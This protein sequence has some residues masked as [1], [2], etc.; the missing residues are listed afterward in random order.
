MAQETGKYLETLQ[1]YYEEEIE[2]EAYFD[3]IAERLTDPDEREKMHLMARVEAVAAA[4]V[5]PLLRKHGLTPRPAAELQASGRASAAEVT[6][7]YAT[8][9]AEWRRSFPAYMD[10]FERLEAMAPPEDLPAL[11]VLTAHEVA[12]IAYL[13]L[14]DE[15]Q[16]DSAAPMRRYIETGT[17]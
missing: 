4:S 10:D 11:R 5:A 8:L 1:L 9:I 14:E 7:D 17:A 6:K 16:P 12:A 2:G 15:G 3:A 13:D